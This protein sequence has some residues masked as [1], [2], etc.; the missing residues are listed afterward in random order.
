MMNDLV[1]TPPATRTRTVKR[2]LDNANVTYREVFT[3]RAGSTWVRPTS[4]QWDTA[5]RALESAGFSVRY[6]ATTAN[7]P[8]ALLAKPE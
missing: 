8:A 3:V 2:I 5:R 6:Q 1:S 7:I 4:R